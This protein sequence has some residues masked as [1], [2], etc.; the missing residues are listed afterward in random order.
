MIETLVENAKYIQQEEGTGPSA[1]EIKCKDEQAA[2]V[3]CMES[4]RSNPDE[5]GPKT[6]LAPVVAAWTECCAKANDEQK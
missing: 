4:I 2:L 3:T 1:C 6:C 5:S